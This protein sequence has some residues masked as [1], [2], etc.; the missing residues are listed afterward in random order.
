MKLIAPPAVFSARFVPRTAVVAL[1]EAPLEAG[2]LPFAFGVSAVTAAAA[3]PVIWCGL[4]SD[5]RTALSIAGSASYPMAK[6]VD[7]SA[8]ELLRAAAAGVTW[9][10]ANHRLC[11]A[12]VRK[13]ARAR[14][15]C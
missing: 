2:R 11:S 5:M 10:P 7:K 9:T 14:A 1:A 12:D 4:A 15:L 6:P 8:R 3:A 13:G